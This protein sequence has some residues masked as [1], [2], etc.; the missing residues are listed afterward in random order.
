MIGLTATLDLRGLRLDE[1]R[2]KAKFAAVKSLTLTA[3]DAQAKLKAEV[4]SD[5]HLRNSWVPQGIRIKPATMGNMVAQ[6]GSIDKYMR[7]HVVGAGEP[8]DAASPISMFD[9]TQGTG[10]IASGG[11]LVMLY[12]SIGSAPTHTVARRK[13][14][15]IDGQKN[16]TFQ[17]Q[18]KGGNV[19]IV[20][21]QSKKQGG[22]EILGVLE[23]KVKIR[24]RFDMFASVSAMA[25]ARFPVHFEAAIA[26]LQR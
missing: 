25:T 11:L 9:R 26:K 5:F 17:I 8:K 14:S 3:K 16:K 21:R 6:V 23:S 18:S 4:G 15:R 13:L 19:L 12:G 20:R 10:R 7:R 24:E 2:G 1:L 22:L